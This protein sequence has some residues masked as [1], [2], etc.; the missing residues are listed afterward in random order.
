MPLRKTV[1]GSAFGYG[2]FGS[3]FLSPGVPQTYNVRDFCAE[4]FS[5]FVDANPNDPPYTALAISLHWRWK[6]E[7]LTID[8]SLRHLYNAEMGRSKYGACIAQ[9]NA[10]VTNTDYLCYDNQQS[11]LHST[12]YILHNFVEETTTPCDEPA[13]DIP[14]SVI[15]DTYWMCRS[16]PPGYQAFQGIVPGDSAILANSVTIYPDRCLTGYSFGGSYS[17]RIERFFTEAEYAIATYPVS[18]NL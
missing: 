12:G 3:E 8:S 4:I 13:S 10:Y 16:T 9:S 14:I 1:S 17:Y 7:V 2:S 6:F 5:A 15:T 11:G 18:I